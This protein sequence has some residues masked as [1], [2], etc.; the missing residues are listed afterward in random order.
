MGPIAH[1]DVAYRRLPQVQAQVQVPP[2]ETS[3]CT[4]SSCE[5]RF[6]G[7]MND[8]LELRVTH[9]PTNFAT[10]S[11]ELL[12]FDTIGARTDALALERAGPF[13]FV[14]SAVSAPTES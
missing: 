10:A 6:R 14:V 5:R 1:Y 11:T 13:E 9:S 2:T 3:S 12:P 4:T 8:T 7:W